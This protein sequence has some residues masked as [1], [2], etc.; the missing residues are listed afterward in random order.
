MHK[1]LKWSGVRSDAVGWGTALQ[2]G[3][4]RVRFL[5]GSLWFFIHFIL[6]VSLWPW[7]RL[8]FEPGMSP[9]GRGGRCVGLTNLPPSCTDFLEILT[10]STSCSRSTM[11]IH[12]V[13]L[14]LLTACAC[15]ELS[16]YRTITGRLFLD[17]VMTLPLAV[18]IDTGYYDDK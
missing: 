12:S 14:W 17:D 4:S 18:N 2:A 1:H 10:A 13:V 16:T 5:M 8:S 6:P 7:G 9:G 15:V 3:R 11:K